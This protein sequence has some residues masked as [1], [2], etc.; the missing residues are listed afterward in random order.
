MVDRVFL[1]GRIRTFAA[2]P[3]DVTALA[4][5]GGR[6]VALGDLPDVRAKAAAGSEE[7][8]LGG[9]LLVPGLRDSHIHPLQGGLDQVLRPHHRAGRRGGLSRRGEPVRR[10]RAWS[11]PGS[12]AAAGR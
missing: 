10:N 2:G 3:P 7:V 12:S 5:S 8:D 11:C 4:V 6:I 9:G 1:N